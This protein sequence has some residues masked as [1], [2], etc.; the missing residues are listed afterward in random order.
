MHVDETGRDDATFRRDRARAVFWI[1]L[2]DARDP[3]V[4]DRHVAE[5]PR[6]A[7]A[8]DNSAT[9][10]NDIEFSH[11]GLLFESFTVAYITAVGARQD[12]LGERQAGKP[13]RDREIGGMVKEPRLG[14]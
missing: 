6:I 2:A 4:L 1:D 8:I 7:G 11:A 10:N 5:K 3:T 12:R 14:G 9:V 13:R